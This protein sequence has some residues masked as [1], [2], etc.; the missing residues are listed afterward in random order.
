[1]WSR[2][3]QTNSSKLL[4]FLAITFPFL[5]YETNSLPSNNDIETWL[6]DKHE[7]RESYDDFKLNFGAEEV[8][9]IALPIDSERSGLSEAVADR[10]TRLPSI[11]VCY[12]PQK[13]ARAMSDLGVAPDLIQ[14]RLT[15]LCRSKDEQTIALMALLS[16]AGIAHRGQ[17]VSDLKAELAYCQ[18]EP[19]SYQLSGAPIIVTEL[20]RLGNTEEAGRFF[21]VTLLISLFLLYRTLKDWKLTFA[22]LGQTL[23]AINLSGAVI[24]WSGGEANFILGA[25][26]IMVM[27][28]TL[29]ASIH[30]VHY[31]RHSRGKD[32]LDQA[33]RLAWKPCFL[34]ML[35]TAIGLASLMISEMGPVRQFGFGAALG[36]VISL[37]VGFGFTPAALI[38]WP[39]KANSQAETDRR[40]SRIAFRVVDRSRFVVTSTI[41]L[42]LV[43]GA[44]MYYLKSQIDPLDFLPQDGKVIQDHQY[45]ES[46]FAST[47]SIEAVV[48]FGGLDMPFTEKLDHIRQLSREIES[49]PSIEYAVS[50]A[51]FFPEQLP[52]DAFEAAAL[53]NDAK[54]SHGDSDFIARGERLWRISARFSETLSVP[55]RETIVALKQ[56]TESQ[57]PVHF[58]GMEILLEHAQLQIFTGF[59]QSF[60]TAFLIITAVMVIS[61]RSLKAGLV[62]MIP[63]LTPVCLIFGLLGWFGIPVEIGTMMTGSIAL[64]LAVDGTFHYLVRYNEAYR[65]GDCSTR[66]ARKALLLTGGA[67]LNASIIT[68]VGMLALGLSSFTP[69]ARFGY[70]MTMLT[71]AAVI[72]DLV[73]LPALLSLRPQ[74]RQERRQ[75]EKLK[76]PH[77]PMHAPQPARKSQLVRKAG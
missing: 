1:M 7:V 54:Q 44:G 10:L 59:W 58:T 6:P 29:A 8:I 68:A 72:G 61:L 56:K 69:T 63:N 12:T 66:A 36:S 3:Y 65:K 49:N 73:L 26:Q 31:Y 43:C 52:T 30:V 24:K 67:I 25:M 14:Q 50:A 75:R 35:T 34:A 70:M 5:A 38:R 41:A 57:I 13:F 64:G 15:G 51:T 46:H 42:I 60:A 21:L 47:A 11:E 48:D 40:L 77:A 18:F 28:F 16:E 9:I 19:E 20:D 62:A 22:L 45:V 53:L 4:L 39:L 27:V 74:R 37:I 32:R 2:F 71:F 55:H 33:L 76:G 17:L 23:W